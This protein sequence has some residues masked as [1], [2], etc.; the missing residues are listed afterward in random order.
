MDFILRLGEHSLSL[1]V[2]SVMILAT[3]GVVASIRD[4]EDY[5]T[6]QNESDA[7]ATRYASLSSFDADS[8]GKITVQEALTVIFS[9]AQDSSP[10]IVK[11]PD[12]IVH[13]YVSSKDNWVYSSSNKPVGRKIDANGNYYDGTFNTNI[14]IINVKT[15]PIPDYNTLYNYLSNNQQGNVF[16]LGN[17]NPLNTG[18]LNTF[19]LVATY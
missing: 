15:E 8:V 11:G 18:D 4:T 6:R 13:V 5:V 19:L 7:Y 17:M 16:Y 10:V 1:I 14:G 2:A 9:R 3:I 12:G